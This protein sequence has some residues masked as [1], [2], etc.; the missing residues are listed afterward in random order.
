MNKNGNTLKL[1]SSVLV[2]GTLVFGSVGSFAPTAYAAVEANSVR[3][4]T[5]SGLGSM[6]ITPDVAYLNI[7]VQTEAKTA[8]ESQTQN[9]KQFAAVEQALKAEGIPAKDIITQQYSTNPQYTYDEKEGRKVIGYETT[10]MVRVTYRDLDKVG[11]LLDNVAKAGANR[12]DGVQ[13]STEKQAVYEQQAL[14]LA[15]KNANTKADTLAKAA[16]VKVNKVLTITE[17]NVT[18]RPFMMMESLM[19]DNA[20]AKS[21]EPTASISK[22]Q[23]ELEARITIQYEIE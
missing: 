19:M 16:G 3:N 7:G 14:E 12:I 9:S 13:L 20:A 17:S 1:L 10:N 21:A 18:N 23:I 11:V 8:L 2:V 6:F 22:G 4:I 15:V 5:V